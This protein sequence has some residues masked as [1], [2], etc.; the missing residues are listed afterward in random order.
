MMYF[1]HKKLRMP[2]QSETQLVQP[3]SSIDNKLCTVEYQGL[4]FLAKR[5]IKQFF[6]EIDDCLIYN[7]T[8]GDHSLEVVSYKK[9]DDWIVVHPSATETIE[10][11]DI[12]YKLG[13]YS[14]RD[15]VKVP[16]DLVNVSQYWKI[17]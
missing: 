17:K 5:F 10:F 7:E 11:M 3:V 15:I 8:Y 4:I 14:V 12:Q 13:I 2:K 9:E 6:D 16:K 1:N